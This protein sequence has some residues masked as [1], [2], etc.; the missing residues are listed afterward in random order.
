MKHTSREKVLLLLLAMLLCPW[1]TIAADNTSDPSRWLADSLP[2]GWELDRQFGQTLPSSDDWWKTFDDPVLDRLIAMGEKNS[3]DLSMALRRMQLARIQWESAKANY[4]PTLGLAAG[5][6][7][8]R[9]SG[10]MTGLSGD[11]VKSEVFSLGLNFSWEI[12]IFGRVAATRKQGKAQYQASEAEYTGAM[13]SLCANIAKAYVQLRMVQSEILVAQSQIQSQEQ[14]A[15]MTQT[16]HEVGLV[17]KLDV[18]QANGVLFSTQSTLPSLEALEK[19]AIASI[20]MLVGVY[21]SEI[22][23]DLMKVQPFPNPYRIIDAGVPMD[24]LRRRPD[25]VEAEKELAGYAA[26]IGIAKKDFLPTLSLTGSI[27]TEAHKFNDLFRDRSFTYSVAPQLSWTIFDGLAR[28]Y[29]VAEAKEQM[30][31][32]IDNYNM[33]VQNAVI[34]TQDAMNTYSASLR[35]IALLQKVVEQYTETYK[36]SVDRYRD[37]LTPFSDVMNAQLSLLQYHNSLVSAKASAFDS[38]IEIYEA[39]GGKPS[40]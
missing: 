34:E 20:A 24:L 18:A 29:R 8:N 4:F 22:E 27:G 25:I 35:Q 15:Y 23:E 2:Q 21:P 5:W 16:R 14:I 9:T 38:L 37:G 12:D 17:S 31:A 40:F 32:G 3:Y 10:D 6:T 28:N 39:L 19:S 7:A 36:L 11:P 1:L 33:T 26:A 30:L 13:I